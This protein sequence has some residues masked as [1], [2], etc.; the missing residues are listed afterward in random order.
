MVTDYK[1][2][3]APPWRFQSDSFFQLQI[4]AVLLHETG[5]RARLLR[6]LFLGGGGDVLELPVDDDVLEAT[7][8]RLRDIWRRM[9][10]AFREDA[11][12]PQTSRLCDWC[13]HKA[14][15]PAFAEHAD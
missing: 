9:I 7:R 10:A 1:T 15:C 11:F 8:G 4:Y 13:A 6:L 5:R 3:K 12:P 14:S 2:G